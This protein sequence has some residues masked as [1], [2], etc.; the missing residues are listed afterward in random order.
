MI[1]AFA[2]IALPPEIRES[3][4]R[5]QAGLP[6]G[7]PAP[8]ENLHLTLVFLGELPEPVLEDVH[9]AF[10]AIRADRFDLTLSGL[11]LFGG[12]RPRNLHACLLENAALCHLQARL[13]TAA[14]RAGASP[15]RRRF[16]PHVTLATLRPGQGDPGRL[17]RA[18]IAG[19]DFRAG[20]FPVESFGLYRSEL[21]RNGAVHT[22]LAQYALFSSQLAFPGP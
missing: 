10:A 4:V 2:A 11:G 18:V 20:P 6:S 15:E 9:L 14:R 21:G 22:E 1:R 5:L 16:S 3:L 19:S 8:P 7:R 12:A 17:E 13:E